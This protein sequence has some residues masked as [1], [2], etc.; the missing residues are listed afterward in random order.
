MDKLHN[1]NQ[2]APS[3]VFPKG[4]IKNITGVILAGGASRRMGSD[5]ALLPILGG[6]L[7]DHV[8]RRMAALFSE[9]LIVTNAP[10]LFSDIPCCKVPDLS[11]VRGSLAG[12]H[13]ALVHASAGKVFVVACDMPFI[14]APMIWHIC[15]FADQGDVVMP[16]SSGGHEPLHAVYSKSCLPAI[17]KVLND[18]QQRVAAFFDQVSLVK[19]SAAEISMLDPQEKCFCNI[20]TP[21]DYFRLRDKVTDQDFSGFSAEKVQGQV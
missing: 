11:A 15:S 18:G 12:I 6:R 1:I 17:E 8:Y 19:L 3:E 20:N 5:K 14:T 16:Y 21:E 7:I 10:E 13:S 2:S 9:L 4:P